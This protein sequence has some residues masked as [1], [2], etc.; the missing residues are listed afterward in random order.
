MT[1]TEIEKVE[2]WLEAKKKVGNMLGERTLEAIEGKAD[3][4]KSMI[5]RKNI[6]PRTLQK[7]LQEEV[8]DGE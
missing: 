5:I 3:N 4:F 7:I 2:K 8:K 6:N 1:K